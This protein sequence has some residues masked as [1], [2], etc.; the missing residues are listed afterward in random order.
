LGR[1]L[2]CTLF[3]C[4]LWHIVVVVVVVLVVVLV[5]DGGGGGG[6]GIV[7][8]SFFCRIFSSYL[9]SCPFSCTYR[10]FQIF[11][12]ALCN[13]ILSFYVLP[14][15]PES[16]LHTHTPGC[17]EFTP[18]LKET[19]ITKKQ[20]IFTQFLCSGKM[21]KEKIQRLAIK[22]YVEVWFDEYILYI[23]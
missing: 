10:L 16:R 4:T 9:F 23:F 2:H 20:T 15:V 7:V 6:G 22:R 8:V 21:R 3:L 13:R 19:D 17:N 11:S 18:C 5:V 14:I 12:S 1:P